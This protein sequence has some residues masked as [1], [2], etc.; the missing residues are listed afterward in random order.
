ME[1]HQE[2]TRT[3]FLLNV[4][5]SFFCQFCFPLQLRL[6]FIRKH[7][8]QWIKQGKKNGYIIVPIYWRSR[9]NGNE[10]CTCCNNI[11]NYWLMHRFKIYLFIHLTHIWIFGSIIYCAALEMSKAYL[12]PLMVWIFLE[13]IFY[14]FPNFPWFE[15]IR[16]QIIGQFKQ[17][18]G[19]IFVI[20]VLSHCSKPTSMML[21]P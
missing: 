16:S 3:L 11:P 13:M 1:T 7:T 5:L 10:L 19:N 12:L 20:L 14:L 9:K 8:W 15:R 4:V 21:R 17:F 6:F 2:V 18:G